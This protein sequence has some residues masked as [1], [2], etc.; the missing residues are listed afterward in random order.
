[1][2]RGIPLTEA[3]RFAVARCYAKWLALGLPIDGGKGSTTVLG[4]VQR[5]HNLP[6]RTIWDCY[7]QWRSRKRLHRSLASTRIRKQKF[8]MCG[9]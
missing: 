7:Q 9:V 1:M 2:P 6:G 8:S 5:R 3:K 4:M